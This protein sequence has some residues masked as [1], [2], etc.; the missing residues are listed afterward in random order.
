MTQSH[1]NCNRVSSDLDSLW[2]Q[3]SE[4][5]KRYDFNN[6][7]FWLFCPIWQ[8]YYGLTRTFKSFTTQSGHIWDQRMVF[9][10]LNKL[11]GEWI[12]NACMLE[13][14]LSYPSQLAHMPVYKLDSR[15]SL[16]VYVKQNFIGLIALQSRMLPMTPALSA[17]ITI[18]LYIAGYKS[19]C[20]ACRVQ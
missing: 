14:T 17:Y 4:V 2:H 11:N 1:S 6:M 9:Y 12:K 19:S 10:T 3:S 20:V 8:Y 16:I 5:S 7:N 13:V 15:S 18:M